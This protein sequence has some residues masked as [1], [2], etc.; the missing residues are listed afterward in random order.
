[1]I[2]RGSFARISLVLIALAS[3]LIHFEAANAAP[4]TSVSD[5]ARTI[6]VSLPGPFNGC[7]FFDAGANPTS[8]AVLDL[9]RPSAFLTNTN[10]NLVG[11]GGPLASAELTSL[12]PETVVYTIAPHQHWSN[13]AAFDGRDLVAWWLRARVL[14]SV[15][16]DGYRAIKTLTLSNHAL[17]LTAVFATP[18]ADWNLLFRDVEARGADM[19]CALAN[20]TSHPSL[21][22]YKVTNA[23]ASRIVLTMNSAWPNDPNRFGRVVLT[24]SGIIPSSVT[25]PFANYSLVVNRA[26]EQALSAHPSVLSHIG[27]SSNIE[28]ITFAP[29]SPLTRSLSVREALSWSLSR[30]SLINQLFGAVTFSPSIAASAI[31][32]QG[33]SAYPGFNGGGPSTQTTTTTVP[34]TTGPV[35]SLTDCLTCAYNVLRAAGFRHISAG[36]VNVDGVALKLQ[37]A[38]G[39]SVDDVAA[40]ALVVKQ[41][42]VAGITTTVVKARSDVTAAQMAA[43][44]AVDAAIFARPTLTAPSYTARSW[45]GPAYTDAFPS[46]VRSPGV[47]AFF[48]SANSNFNPVAANATWLLLDQSIMTSFW[49]RPLFTSPSLE[50]W[51]SSLSGVVGSLSVSGFLDQETNWNSVSIS[52]S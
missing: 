34:S 7:T 48:K 45:S 37:L 4:S 20:L 27:T 38:V 5:N 21:G 43:A 31:F 30:Q 26:Q 49:V 24:T 40:A 1:M 44:N 33:Q 17:K 47:T 32:S 10:G 2:P 6:T 29:L 41:W 3:V 15:Q 22:P 25:T 50:E 11:E 52:H 13:G 23:T 19:G 51:A 36:W 16:S 46:G 42:R 8:N 35:P 14:A 12:Q 18:F 9:I 39:P 28:E